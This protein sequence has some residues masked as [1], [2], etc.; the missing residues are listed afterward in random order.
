MRLGLRCSPGGLVEVL[1]PSQVFLEELD[2]ATG[3]AIV[4]TM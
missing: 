4:V 2:G 3:S 1:N